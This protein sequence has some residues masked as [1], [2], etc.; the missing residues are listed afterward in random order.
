MAAVRQSA[1]A[2]RP[3]YGRM[4]ATNGLPPSPVQ[5]ARDGPMARELLPLANHD[6]KSQVRSGLAAGGKWI[7]TSSSVPIGNTL[8]RPRRARSRVGSVIRAVASQPN[9]TLP[10]APGALSGG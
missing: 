5:L 8:H 1:S 2:E 4:A 3:A 7:R 6:R 10:D 9:E